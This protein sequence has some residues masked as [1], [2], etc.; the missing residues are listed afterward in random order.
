MPGVE[1]AT[2]THVAGRAAPVLDG[3]D[4]PAD[5]NGHERDR[6][7][8]RSGKPEQG[9]FVF[10]EWEKSHHGKE[11]HHPDELLPEPPGVGILECGL[12]LIG[13]LQG[14]SFAR[15]NKQ[16]AEV[17]TLIPERRLQCSALPRSTQSVWSRPMAT[18]LA[19]N[20]QSREHTYEQSSFIGV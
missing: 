14:L 9:R 17:D 7:E 13:V 2:K 20:G 8:D 3:K 12:L 15:P 4:H 18:D 11:E 1:C 10:D 19:G 5:K 16:S 6:A